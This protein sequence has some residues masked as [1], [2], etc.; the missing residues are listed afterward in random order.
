MSPCLDNSL[1]GLF[2]LWHVESDIRF[3]PK[4]AEMW[5]C[6]TREHVSTVF[7]SISDDFGPRELLSCISWCRSGLCLMTMIFQ[8]TPE[9]N[10]SA[11]RLDSHV[12]SAA[13]ST[14]G[15]YVS[16]FPPTPW[17]FSQYYELWMVKVL[18]SLQSCTEK[19]CLWTDC[20]FSH[21][22]WHK[23]VNHDPSLLVKTTPLVDALFILLY[24][25]LITSPV[26]S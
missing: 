8:T 24:T 18:N 21:E 3:S 12:Y 16:R 11:W 2:H 5:T 17:I 4:Q 7:W 22:V 25:I 15:L 23:A 13:V 20:Q 9:P 10:N 26:T 6:L 1:D 14:F 19:N